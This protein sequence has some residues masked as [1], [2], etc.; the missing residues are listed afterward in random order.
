MTSIGSTKHWINRA[1][2]NFCTVHGIK[3]IHSNTLFV[4][5]DKNVGKAQDTFIAATSNAA[6]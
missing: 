6:T 4:S 3:M 2:S 5:K 1:A